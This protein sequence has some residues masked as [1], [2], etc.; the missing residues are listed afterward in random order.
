MY[1]VHSVEMSWLLSVPLSAR[2]DGNLAKAAGQD[3]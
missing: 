1:R 3:D 2:V